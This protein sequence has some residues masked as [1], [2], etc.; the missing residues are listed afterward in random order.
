ML[1]C[2]FSVKE[3]HLRAY[4]ET[5]SRIDVSHGFRVFRFASKS[6]HIQSSCFISGHFV[7]PFRNLLLLT[8]SYK[9]SHYKQY[10]PRTE[11]IYSYF[12]SRGGEFT[13][14]VF[15]GL[16]YL[17]IEYL[18]GCV[19]TQE[20]IDEAQHVLGDH[21]SESSFFN[22]AGWEYIANHCSGRLPI[23]I[24]AVPEGS[25]LPTSNVL[26]T[27][28]NTDPTCY[29][30]TNYLETLL[31]QTWYPCTVATQSRGMKQSIAQYLMKTGGEENLRFKLHDFGFRG[32]SSVETA[33]IGGASHLV[34][35]NGTDNLAGIILAQK[36]YG[37]AMPGFSI[38]AAEHSTLTSWGRDHELDAYRN[39]LEQ[40]PSG[41]VAVVSDSYD[42]MNACRALWGREL[43]SMILDRKGTLVIRPDSG[44]PPTI[45]CEVLEILGNAFGVTK[46]SQ[47]YKMLDPHIRVIQG[48]GIDRA[49][50][51]RILEAITVAG[52]S[53]DNLAFGSG[54]GL[55][56]KLHRDTSK[57]AF[58][59][60]S[61]RINGSER[62]VFKQPVTDQGKKSKAGR[63]RL[64][65]RNGQ[66]L[67]LRE[68]ESR[69][70][71]DHLEEVFLNG[72]VIRR[73]SWSEIC[74][75]AKLSS[76]C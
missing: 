53:A 40:F 68:S 14:T 27:I 56:Q 33:A 60:S 59:C 26:M 63:L 31:V 4:S 3:H 34:N 51:S 12:E 48:D 28:E 38:P 1:A 19:V 58:K 13:E 71:S 24:K 57:Y 67:T 42:L 41:M 10:P 37:A 15:F 16:Q 72:E 8:D 23:R 6:V 32:V 52:W 5:I 35:F 65:K 70:D 75:R 30:L 62:D 64:V 25:V 17:L 69:Q 7:N 22:R 2:K 21:F 45:L 76:E 29:W 36:Y 46:N 39:M 9:V 49:M 44:D 43:K 74:E 47:G 54:G 11:T 61:A 55:L 18:E 73:H 66:Y 50:L 20:K